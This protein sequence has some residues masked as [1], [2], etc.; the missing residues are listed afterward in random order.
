V[1]SMRIGSG[2]SGGMPMGAGTLIAPDAINR[3][4]DRGG[5]SARLPAETPPLAPRLGVGG[6]GPSGGEWEQAH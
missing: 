3:P 1:T 5:R 6:L 2:S 4:L